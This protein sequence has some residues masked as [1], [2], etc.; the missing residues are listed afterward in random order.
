MKEVF[1]NGAK[2]Y[3]RKIIVIIMCFFICVSIYVLCSAGFSK[4]VGYT[5]IGYN[6]SNKESK[7]L[8]TYYYKDGKDTK[9][10]AYEQQGF[11]IK[12]NKISQMTKKGNIVFLLATQIFCTLLTVVFVY[13][14]LWEL[15]CK[16]SNLVKFKH[17]NEDIFKGLKI[18]LIA[19]VPSFIIFIAF[20][21]GTLNSSE[22]STAIYK[23]INCYNYSFIDI[24][25]KNSP[26]VGEISFSKYL[27]MFLLLFVIP[28][29]A[30][31]AYLL[32]YKDISL[33]EK[34]VYKKKKD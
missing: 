5:A 13:S 3:G 18:G 19:T 28:L 31:V 33:S 23:F 32:G 16:D 30:F 15:G 22:I 10:E 34:F 29:V 17:K 27:I 14:P 24:I 7:E 2:L 12:T 4:D 6:E 8:Y 1:V 21:I 9:K 11:E 20:V 26:T 25:L